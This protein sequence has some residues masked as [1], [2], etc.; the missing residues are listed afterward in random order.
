MEFANVL[1]T[2]GKLASAWRRLRWFCR[3]LCDGDERRRPRKSRSLTLMPSAPKP[4]PTTSAT[5]CPLRTPWMY[6]RGRLRGAARLLRSLSLLQA[7]TTSRANAAGNC[8]QRNAAARREPRPTSTSRTRCHPRG[9][10]QPRSM[11]RRTR[12]PILPANLAC[13]ARVCVCTTLDTARLRTPPGSVGVDVRRYTR[14]CWRGSMAIPRRYLVA[15]YHWPA[16][17]W[18]TLPSGA[19][20]GRA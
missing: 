6:M 9:G 12:R 14:L 7:S 2:R 10:H 16:W 5:P 3:R 11:R 1:H 18:M 15:R 19:R 17:R 20:D 4:R 8:S 13:P